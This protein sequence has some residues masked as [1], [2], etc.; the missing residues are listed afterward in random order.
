MQIPACLNF[1]HPSHSG[2][3]FWVF[4]TLKL[5]FLVNTEIRHPNYLSKRPINWLVSANRNV[6]QGE[7]DRPTAT[8]ASCP[9]A[10]K[11]CHGGRICTSIII[12]WH[13]SMFPHAAE[14]SLSFSWVPQR[15]F[16]AA[17]T[18][19]LS[20]ASQWHSGHSPAFQSRWGK[21]LIAFTSWNLNNTE[22]LKHWGLL[23]TSQKLEAIS[24]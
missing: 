15:C 21:C 8:Q 6:C 13:T 1:A 7:M 20:R 10:T 24:E 16:K 19:Q 5:C 14:N 3:L 17:H 4:S 11:L 18:P 22:W 23:C 2:T 12:S 9:S